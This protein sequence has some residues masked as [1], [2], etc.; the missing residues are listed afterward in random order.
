MSEKYEVKIRPEK[1]AVVEEM[2]EKLGT[3]S[4]IQ[5]HQKYPDPHRS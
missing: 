5:S 3:R 2:K 4:R 1:V